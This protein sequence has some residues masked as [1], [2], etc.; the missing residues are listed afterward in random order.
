VS[1]GI[2]LGQILQ[3]A[4]RFEIEVQTQFNLLQKTMMMAEGVARQLNPAA[5]M[6]QLA[7]PLAEDWMQTE[8][9]IPRQAAQFGRDLHRL[10]Q[11]LPKIIDALDASPPPAAPV[12]PGRVVMLAL[13]LAMISF[14]MEIH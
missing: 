3:I 8:A 4:N 5:D 6:W 14:F 11:R 12:W 1:L 2:V 10:V 7:R 9:S 13:L